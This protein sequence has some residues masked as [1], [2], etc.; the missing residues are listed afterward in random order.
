MALENPNRRYVRIQGELLNGADRVRRCRQRGVGAGGTGNSD[1]TRFLRSEPLDAGTAASTERRAC[2]A[3]ISAALSNGTT[4]VELSL[5]ANLP[6][7]SS[8]KMATMV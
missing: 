7:V 1:G 4:T 2:A 5:S 3:P 6:N 8:C